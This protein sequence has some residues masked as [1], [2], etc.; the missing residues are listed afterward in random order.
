MYS[1]LETTNQ[2]PQAIFV[3]L[4]QWNIGRFPRTQKLQKTC[5]NSINIP[6]HLPL[7]YNIEEIQI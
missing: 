4:R 5:H 6:D 2:K 3:V 1:S 7:V